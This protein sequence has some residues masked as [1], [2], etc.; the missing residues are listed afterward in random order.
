MVPFLMP[1]CGQSRSLRMSYYRHHVFFCINQREDGR[2]C[3]A[4]CGASE[5]RDFL[6]KRAKDLGLAGPGG[7]RINTAGCLDR[8][9]QG[10]VIVIYPE[11]TWYTYVDQEDVEEILQE[12]LIEGRRVE[13]LLLPER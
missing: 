8:C 9:D 4:Q 3:C 7:V 10:P 11:A 2:Q 5:L 13:R 1:V 6:K 12:H